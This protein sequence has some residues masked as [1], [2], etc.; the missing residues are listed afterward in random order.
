M[1]PVLASRSPSLACYAL[2]LALVLVLVLVPQGSV[3]AQDLKLG[4]VPDG[5]SRVDPPDGFVASL[6]HQESLSGIQVAQV[7]LPQEDLDTYQKTLVQRLKERGMI[8]VSESQV[9]VGNQQAKLFIL[10]HSVGGQQFQVLL[11]AVRGGETVWDVVAHLRGTDDSSEK[12][13]AGEVV[14]FAS[15]LVK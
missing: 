3:F 4:V 1:R 15:S 8:P 7:D 6:R 11:I 9:K 13:L 12:Q 14:D 10:T 2:P 5:W